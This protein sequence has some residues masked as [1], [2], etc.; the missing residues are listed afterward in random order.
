MCDVPRRKPNHSRFWMVSRSGAAPT[1]TAFRRHAATHGVDAGDGFAFLIGGYGRF[2]AFLAISIV[3]AC[4]SHDMR[5]YHPGNNISV[6]SSGC[7]MMAEASKVTAF[8]GDVRSAS[9]ALE[10]VVPRVK[11]VLHAAPEAS[12]LVFD[13]VTGQSLISICAAALRM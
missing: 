12:V 5:Y 10:D 9:G 1:Q 6:F 4:I 3:L 8:K 7:Y 2:P 11:A 13:D